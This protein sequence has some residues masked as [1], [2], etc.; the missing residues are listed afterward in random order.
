MPRPE[1]HDYS[2]AAVGG[3][4]LAYEA[5]G[6]GAPIVFVHGGLSDLRTW[7]QQAIALSDRFHTVTYSRRHAWPNQDIADGVEDRTPGHVDDLVHFLEALNAPSAHLVG[8]SWGGLI[9]LLLAIDH[10]ERVQSMVLVEPPVVPLIASTP[11]KALEIA[12]LLMT[13]PRTAFALVSFFLRSV[14]PYASASRKGDDEGA[15]DAFWRGALGE[16]RLKDKPAERLQIAYENMS[17]MRSQIT[18]GFPPISARQVRRLAIATLLLVGSE[19]PA[20]FRRLSA[21]LSRLIAD[22]TIVEVESAAHDMHEDQ[23]D[24]VSGLI[25][26]FVEKVEATTGG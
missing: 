16:Q 23:P 17:T 1:R 4:E 3:T 2:T 21:L 11:P 14:K 25:A 26:D 9:V 20:L 13:D 15:V 18:G 5:F 19:S 24:L 22:S 6:Q 8:H 10:P 12:R 7:R